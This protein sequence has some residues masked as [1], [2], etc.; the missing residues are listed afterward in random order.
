MLKYIF[1]TQLYTS[2]YATDDTVTYML[3]HAEKL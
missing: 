2:V 3:P 1:N